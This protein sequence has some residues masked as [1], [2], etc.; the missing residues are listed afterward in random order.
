M[1]ARENKRVDEAVKSVG[2]LLKLAYN[3]AQA[4]DVLMSTIA[5]RMRRFGGLRRA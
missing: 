4:T 2:N 5:M 3:F 1:E